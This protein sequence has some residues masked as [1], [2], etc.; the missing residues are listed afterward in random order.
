MPLR[1]RQEIK[2]AKTQKE[3]I[4]NIDMFKWISLSITLL[5]GIITIVWALA[6]N[7]AAIVNLKDQVNNMS[8]MLEQTF[9]NV[10]ALQQE[11]VSLS[12]KLEISRNYEQQQSI[13]LKESISEI[14]R[15][16]EHLK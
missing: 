9:N 1:L 3:I 4:M 12:E 7:D 13:D 11:V 16:Q 15:S 6:H 14:R 2:N 5:G 8:V 10:T